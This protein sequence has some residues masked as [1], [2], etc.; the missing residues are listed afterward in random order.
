MLIIDPSV[1]KNYFFQKII[2]SIDTEMTMR[3]YAS[4]KHRYLFGGEIETEKSGIYALTEVTNKFERKG[5]RN[6]YGAN[7]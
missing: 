6:A 2:F 7:N 3:D 1:Y 4:R 5:R